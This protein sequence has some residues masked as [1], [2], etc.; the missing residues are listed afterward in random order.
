MTKMDPANPCKDT[1]QTLPDETRDAAI[2]RLYDVALAPDRYEALLDLWEDAV[3]PLRG[4][5]DLDAPRLLE[6]PLI[7]GHFERASAFL[8]RVE[9]VGSATELRDILRPFGRMS[10]FLLDTSLTVCAGNA[11]AL[12]VS[13]LKEGT[14]LS[15]LRVMPE[16]IDAISKAARNVLQSPQQDAA[17]LRVRSIE[18]NHYIILR[19]QLCKLADETPL[20]LAA[21]NDI[22]FS[23]DSQEI[24]QRAF[25]LTNAEAGVL[26]GLVE[27]GSVSDIAE[28]RGR[29]VDTIRAQIKA[30]MSKTEAHSQVELVR[31]A[32]SVVDMAGM[33]PENMPAPRQV[34]RGYATLE[35]SVF[36]S[37]RTPDGRQ[38]DY[39][40]LGDQT[41]RPILF[42]PLD[43]GLV[44]WPASAEA[45][46]RRLGLRIIVPVR[47]GFGAS[48]PLP[49]STD[50]DDAATTDCLQILDAENVD[51]CPIISLGGDSF[52]AMQLALRSPKTITGLICCAGTLPMTRREQYERMEKWHRFIIAG[53]KYTPHLLPF[54][55]KA[56]FLLAR[57]IG[58]QGFVHAVY[59]KCPA[60]V[61]TFESPEVFEAMV[62]GSE[63]ALSETHS[64]H[65]AFVRMLTGR[66]LEDWSA[67]VEALRGQ[68]PVIFMNGLQDPQ[69][70]PA[71]LDE[72]RTTYDWIDY[73]VYEDAGQLIFFRHWRDVLDKAQ[74]L[75][76]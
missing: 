1:R 39:L 54:M 60:D 59:G 55:V 28:K 11:A 22:Y 53:A 62:T 51:R 64:A 12:T 70:P 33:T 9:T 40:R 69:V 68:L 14:T 37:L 67:D 46:A 42:L 25:D 4:Q 20:V 75:L 15:D 57:R 72:F 27:C 32:L 61:E 58:K 3:R 74:Q 43:Y 63:V 73:H 23:E 5:A 6:D 71:T 29:S 38:L 65:D 48:D 44:R 66:F 16:D 7:A 56:G 2:S 10:A 30:I 35:P 21:S 26:L 19:L 41:G 52:Y 49:R 34:S 45:E 36:H 18:K 24:L 76:P 50:Y 8:D 17:V 13:G 47:A 31:L